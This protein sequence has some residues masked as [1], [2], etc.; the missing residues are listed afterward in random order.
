[1][2]NSFVALGIGY[3]VL[4][5]AGLLFYPRSFVTMCCKSRST[6]GSGS[7]N[8]AC[9]SVFSVRVCGAGFHG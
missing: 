3:W 5:L 2:P 7:S 8:S 4:S 1:M 9:G 6:H